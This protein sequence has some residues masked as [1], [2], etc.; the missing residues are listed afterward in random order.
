MK[1]VYIRTFGCQMNVRD[2]EIIFGLLEN[3]G[4][5]KAILTRGWDIRVCP[6]DWRSS[7]GWSSSGIPAEPIW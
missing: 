3:K 6:G 5:L 2:S 1:K 4:F 7:A